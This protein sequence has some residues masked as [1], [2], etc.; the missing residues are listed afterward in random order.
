[1]KEIQETLPK[2]E[3]EFKQSEEEHK[4]LATNEK[5]LSEQVNQNRQKY[6]E[7][8]SNFSS[9]RNRGSVLSFLMKLKSEGKIEGIYGRLVI[10]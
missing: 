3:I 1:M 9:N 6:S 7:A 5:R 8:Q 4:L 10:N 2:F